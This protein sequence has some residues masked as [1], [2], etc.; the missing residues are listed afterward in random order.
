MSD[1]P[2]LD[3]GVLEGDRF[4]QFDQIVGGKRLSDGRIAVANAGSLELRYYDA[5]G[6]HLFSTGREGGGPGEFG[7]MMSLGTP[8][9]LPWE[10]LRRLVAEVPGVVSVT[11]NLATKPPSTMEVV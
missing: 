9:A 4:Y 7:G 8:T 2:I 11:Y 6:K 5:E 3:I 10:T 1:E